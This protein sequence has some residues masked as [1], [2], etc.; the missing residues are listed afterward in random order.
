M[1]LV[2]WDERAVADLDAVDSSIAKKIVA[3]ISWL[4]K[5]HVGIVPELLHYSLKGIYKLRVGDYRV[6]Y[7][8][9]GETITIL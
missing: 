8:V 6:L 9:S 4:K 3:K 5:Y 1:V 2:K 7:K